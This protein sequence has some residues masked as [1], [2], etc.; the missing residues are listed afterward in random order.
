[1]RRLAKN[2]GTGNDVITDFVVGQDHI[3]LRAFHTNFD[4]LVDHDNFGLAGRGHDDHDDPVTLKT[5]GHDTVLAF[6]DGGTVRIEGVTH[7][8]AS[9]FVF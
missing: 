2:A 8:H 9:D 7:L 5:E 3:D 6:A 1:M 4:A